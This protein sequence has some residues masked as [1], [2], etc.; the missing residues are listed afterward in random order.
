MLSCFLL[1]S[2]ESDQDRQEMLRAEGRE[3]RA[4]KDWQHSGRGSRRGRE[5]NLDEIL[6]Q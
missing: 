4:F 3:E 6:T 1:S 5:T 2:L